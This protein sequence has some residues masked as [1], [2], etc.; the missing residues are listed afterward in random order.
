MKFLIALALSLSTTSLMASHVPAVEIKIDGTAARFVSP[1]LVLGDAEDLPPY[2]YDAG[3]KLYL[4]EDATPG[5]YT[6]VLKDKDYGTE[7]LTETLNVKASGHHLS[8][9]TRHIDCSFHDGAIDCR[10]YY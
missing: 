5:V 6:L 8:G 2:F 10:H 9:A 1:E 4:W 3:R 7:L